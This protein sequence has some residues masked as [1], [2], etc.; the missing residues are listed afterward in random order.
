MSIA[1]TEGLDLLNQGQFYFTDPGPLHA[2]I[3][4]FSL[5][6]DDSLSLVLETEVPPEA[7]STAVR[8]PSGTVRI[9]TDQAK[10]V[11]AAGVQAVLTGVQTLTVN[12]LNDNLHKGVARVHQLTVTPGDLGKAAYTV[13]WLNNLTAIPFIWPNSIHTE[14]E[15]TGTGRIFLADEH[16]MLSGPNL[17]A[18][19]RT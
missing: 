1:E 11:N 14:R 8:Y 13:E 19:G 17:R 5:H 12:W 9:N 4:G 3:H 18:A 16:I 7:K 6:R 15:A 2:P 10:L